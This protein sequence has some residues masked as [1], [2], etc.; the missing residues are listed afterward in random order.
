MPN[1][2][3]E[4]VVGSHGGAHSCK[5]PSA[6]SSIFSALRPAHL[7]FIAIPLRGLPLRGLNFYDM[8]FLH[9]KSD[10]DLPLYI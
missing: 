10:V 7:L 4:L 5:Q 2:N 9:Q 1:P 3:N 6:S 8:K